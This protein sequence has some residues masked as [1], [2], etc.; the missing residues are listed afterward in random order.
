[1]GNKFRKKREEF[2][3]FVEQV[4][5]DY[6]THCCDWTAPGFRAVALHRFGVWAETVGRPW[7][8]HAVLRLIYRVLYVHVRNHYTIELPLRTKVGRRLIIAHQ[9]GI[10]IHSFSRIGDDCLIHQNVT[11][12]SPTVETILHAP[13]LGNRVEVG[14]GA[15][16]IG[17]VVIGDDVR[18]GPNAVITMNVPAGSTVVA[19]APRVVKLR[20]P[21]P[22]PSAPAA[23]ATSRHD[24][25][26]AQ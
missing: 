16:I 23:A 24:E 9:G 4:R 2:Q 5:E 20:R 22:S 13:I 19:A 8:L 26:V 1:M 21:A 3:R 18:I 25:P 15:A 6:R 11:L 12:G 7:L 10:V 17:K 14:C